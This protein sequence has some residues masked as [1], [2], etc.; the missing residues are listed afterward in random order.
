MKAHIANPAYRVRCCRI[1]PALA[2]TIRLTEYPVDLTMAGGQ[3]YLSTSGYQLTGYSAVASLAPSSLDI[4]GIADAAGVSRAQIASGLFDGAAVYVFATT[5]TAPYEDEE[6][7]VKGYLGQVE[8]M[9][10]R[11]RVN[12]LSLSDVL[13]QSVGEAYT[14]QCSKVFLSAGFAGCKVPAAAN[15]VTGT[16]TSV[17]SAS[18]FRDAA[19]VE[20]ADAFGAGTFR[21][22]SGLN[23]NL[24]AIEVKSYTG[25][26]TIQTFESF[27]YLPAVGDSYVMQRGCRKRL[28]D[29]QTRWNG[30]TTYNNVANFGG[31]PW[32]P[33]ASVYAKWGRGG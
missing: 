22:T 23:A 3:L 13:N 4:E 30:S 2:A 16:L 18:V 24:R 33:V 10:G 27:P 8:L 25:D 7:M 19:R 14:T 1:V 9:D 15:T 12:V 21:F 31:F 32:I 17:S 20:A 29:C 6:P 26:G 11:W 28:S 5:W